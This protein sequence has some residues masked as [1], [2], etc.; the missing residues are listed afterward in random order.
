[1]L[2][3]SVLGTIRP[4]SLL[5]F[6]FIVHKVSGL[7]PSHI[8][9]K[10]VLLHQRSKAMGCLILDWNLQNHEP[11]ETFLFVTELSQ[12]FC[13]RKPTNTNSDQRNWE[14]LQ[15]WVLNLAT[16]LTGNLSKPFHFPVFLSAKSEE[17]I[18]SVPLLWR[19]NGIRK[20]CL[21]LSLRPGIL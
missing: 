12:A 11:T 8:P 14:I 3:H 19:W 10:G 13:A 4:R 1:M 18:F 16:F 9:T 7:T 21:I 20:P 5:L 17:I 2:S 6:C 15:T